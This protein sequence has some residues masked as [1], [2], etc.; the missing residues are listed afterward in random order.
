VVVPSA[1]LWRVRRVRSVREKVVRVLT[2]MVMIRY[3]RVEMGGAK[4]WDR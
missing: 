3:V 2:R 4:L 1:V